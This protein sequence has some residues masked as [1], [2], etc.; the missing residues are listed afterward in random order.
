[1]SR[2]TERVERILQRETPAWGI[3]PV[4]AELRQLGGLDLGV[5]WFDLSIG[6]LVMVTGALL[7]PP[8]GFG[9]ALLAIAVGTLIGCVPLALVALAG[10]REGVPTMVLLR[11]VLGARGSAVPSALNVIQLVGWT[12]VEFWVM[13]EVANLVSA[14][15]FGFESRVFWLALVAIVCTGLA[16]GGPVLVVRRWLERFG[17]YVLLGAAVWITV[18]VLRAG[19]LGSIW[20]APGQGELP[21]WLAVDLVVVM[22]VS[23]LP[24]A[25]DY[26]RFARPDARGAL[27]TYVGYAVGNAWFYALGA[28]LVL[29]ARASADAIGIGS[30]IVAVAGGGLVLVALLVGESDNAFA[31][32][33]SAA[34]S[35]Q[36]VAY[37]V[38][39]RLLVG[40][41]GAVGFVLALAFTAERYE[42]FLFLIGSVF[43]PLAAVFVADYFVRGRG[44][45]GEQGVFG[46]GGVRWL[47]FVP[48]IAGFVAYQW[49]VPTG[50]QGWVDAVGRVFDALALP[51]PLFDGG[52]GASIPAFV[53]A[54]GLALLLPRRTPTR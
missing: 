15:L 13:G 49:C 54:F 3:R 50:P 27:G 8:L 53:V 45:Y 30:A 10:Q 48:W 36:N 4:P 37:E 52:L 6:L 9:S 19:E 12:A 7:V 35:T 28:L 18:E 23:W 24:L 11:P 17:I 43:V 1:V 16:M 51:F 42:Q 38:S 46:A 32:I 29:V 34:V 22:P 33:Y 41:V 14:Q 31:D 2:V 20:R 39:Q 40:V 25:A 5:L 26:S 21:F 44:R 47:S